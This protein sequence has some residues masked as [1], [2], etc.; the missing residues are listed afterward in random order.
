MRCAAVGKNCASFAG[1]CG[2]IF[3]A[4]TG[5]K[6]LQQIAHANLIF[7]LHVSIGGNE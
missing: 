5:S 2:A 7:G 6:K 1:P 4:E 3:D